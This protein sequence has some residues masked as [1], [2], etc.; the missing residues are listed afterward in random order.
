MSIY[1]DCPDRPEELPRCKCF[2]EI[3]KEDI[4]IDKTILG[5]LGNGRRIFIEK[6]CKMERKPLLEE[7]GDG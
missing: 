1:K 2:I 6:E 4:S 3:P 5:E 7:R